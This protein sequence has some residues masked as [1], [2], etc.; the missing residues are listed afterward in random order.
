MILVL[1]EYEDIWPL[2]DRLWIGELGQIYEWKMLEAV[3]SFRS[4]VFPT[5]T[6][7]IACYGLNIGGNKM[8]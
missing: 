4:R 1:D 7:A 5:M 3:G 6:R 2:E 8:K